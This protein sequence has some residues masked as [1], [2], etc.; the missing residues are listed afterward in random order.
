[1]IFETIKELADSKGLSIRVVEQKAGL[2][3]G[4][5]T[6][7]RTSSPTIEKLDKVAKALGVPVTSLIKKSRGGVK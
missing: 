4:T 6:S 2:G 5:I 1:M 7:W 3:N